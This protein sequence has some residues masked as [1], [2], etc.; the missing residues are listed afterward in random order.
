MLVR[1]RKTLEAAGLTPS[2]PP[3]RSDMEDAV[4]DPGADRPA[5]EFA[6]QLSRDDALR[7]CVFRIELVQE[8]TRQSAPTE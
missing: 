3:P 7:T 2:G 8:N 6:A 5:A 1:L 4:I